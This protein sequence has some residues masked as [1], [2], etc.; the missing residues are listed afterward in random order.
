VLFVGPLRYAQVGSV[1]YAYHRFGPFVKPGFGAPPPG[2]QVAAEAGARAAQQEQA[3]QE[4]RERAPLVF[5]SGLGMTMYKWPIPVSVFAEVGC[6]GWGGGGGAPPVTLCSS[7][8]LV[9]L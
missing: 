1:R 7:D 5:I 9:S 6:C 3:Q 2:T 4:R 8:M